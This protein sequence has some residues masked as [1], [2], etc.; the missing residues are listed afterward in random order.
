METGPP[1]MMPES[2]IN[3]RTKAT[4]LSIHVHVNGLSFFTHNEQGLASAIVRRKFADA[5]SPEQLHDQ[6]HQVLK[7]EKLLTQKFSQVR[8]SV[9]NNLATLVP[10]ALFELSALEEYLHKDID[11]KP[12]DFIAHDLLPNTDWVNVYVPFVNVNNMLLDN[13]G[14]FNY[15]HAVSV[16]LDALTKHSQADGKQVW[17]VY[18]EG[19]N[20]HIALFQNDK[21]HYYTCFEASNPKDITYYILFTAKELGINPAEVP[22]FV[23]GDFIEGDNTFKELYTFVRSI[24]FIKPESEVN[25]SV[26]QLNQHQ[27]FCLLNL[28]SCGLFQEA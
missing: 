26:P 3:Q 5:V 1:Y 19:K 6:L 10:Q 23:V 14:S 15:Y 25:L 12:G 7:Q 16:W 2:K 28:H 18:K 27:D 24:N 11:L 13:F 22:L 9:E 8:C 4:H 17:G 20:L 21:L